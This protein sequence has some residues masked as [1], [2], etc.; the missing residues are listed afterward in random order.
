MTPAQ[1]REAM[2]PEDWD[3]KFEA[4]LADY[5][6]DLPEGFYDEK[7]GFT[8]P[9]QLNEIF[10]ELEEKN[11]YLIHSSQEL[12]QSVEQQNQVFKD[13]KKQLEGEIAKIISNKTKLE[14]KVT[15]SHLQLA[16]LEIQNSMTTAVSGEDQADEQ[17]NI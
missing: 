9:N 8:D 2:R 14:G 17:L 12:E 11:L 10:A 1:R 13:T 6:I 5:L 3:L 16:E 4:M 15:E 7:H